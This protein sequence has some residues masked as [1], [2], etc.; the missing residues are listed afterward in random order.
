MRCER[1]GARGRVLWA[2]VDEPE[3][4]SVVLFGDEVLGLVLCSPCLDRSERDGP[5]DIVTRLDGRGMEAA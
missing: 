3:E 5:W 2:C 1:C 4:E